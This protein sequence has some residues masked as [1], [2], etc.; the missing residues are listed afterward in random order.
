M[1]SPQGHNLASGGHDE[2]IKL[3]DVET[4][5]CIKTFRS[6]RPYEGLN[7]SRVAGLSEAQKDT[8]KALGAVELE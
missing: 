1:F 4:G 3:W 7:I 8:L 5:E 6:E 2:T